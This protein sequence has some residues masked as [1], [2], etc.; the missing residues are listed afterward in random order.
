[1]SK[2]WICWRDAACADLSADTDVRV[3]IDSRKFERTARKYL[4]VPVAT[5][6]HAGGRR[7]CWTHEALSV[8]TTISS[9]VRRQALLLAV[10]IAGVTVLWTSATL[11][12]AFIES[13]QFSDALIERYPWASRLAFV[14]LGGVSGML[15]LFS[16][17]A[18]VPVAVS[19]WGQEQTL[20]LLMLGWFIGASAAYVIGRRFGRRV[21]EHFVAT[22]T[23]AHYEGLLTKMSVT[24]VAI[25]KLALPSEVPSF[26]MGIARYPVVTFLIVVVASEVP[27]AVWVVYLTAALIEDR[28][29]AFLVVLIGGFAAAAL[30]TYRLLRRDGTK[31]SPDPPAAHVPSSRS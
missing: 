24:S 9:P 18:I 7:Q 12:S 5:T 3:R 17:V 13:L 23:L 11:H 16:S 1:M 25:L 29:A 19:A 21:A 10:V 30:I 20:V 28:R 31:G 26:A 6:V 14:A 4:F 2:R 15:I 22:A 8:K 27:A